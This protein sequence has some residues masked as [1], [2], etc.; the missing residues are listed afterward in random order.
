MSATM[1]AVPDGKRQNLEL[2]TIEVQDAGLDGDLYT[3]DGQQVF[4]TQGLFVP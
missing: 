3:N 1:L 2:R 4:L